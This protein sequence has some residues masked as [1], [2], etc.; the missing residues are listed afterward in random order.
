[1]TNSVTKTDATTWQRLRVT[2]WLMA[3]TSVCIGSPCSAQLYDP[4]DTYPPRWYLG[5]TDCDAKI[6]EQKHLLDGGVAGGSCEVINFAAANGS[7]AQLVYPIEPVLPLDDLIASVKVMSAKPGA[8]IGFRVRFPYVKD[9][10]T[11]KVVAVTL[12]GADYKAPGEFALLGI[13]SIEKSLRLKHVALRGEYGPGVDLADPYVDAVLINAY[14]GAGTTAIRIDELRVDGMVPVG[15]ELTDRSMEQTVPGG[16]KDSSRS[17]LLAE[18]GPVFPA[19]TVTRILQ[20]NG[21][22]LG[23]VR[24]LGFDAILTSEMPDADLL[25]A[26]IQNRLQIYSPPPS[27]IDPVLESLLE[28]VAGWFLGSSDVLDTSTLDQ[29]EKAVQRLR[30]FPE[31][32]QRPMI[33]APTES[34]SSYSAFLDGLIQDLPPRERSLSADEEVKELNRRLSRI[35]SHVGQG[36]AVTSMP[37]ESILRQADSIAEAVGVPPPSSFH[38]HAMWLQTMRSLECVPS[39]VLYRST[40]SLA[41]GQPMDTQR[42]LALSYVNRMIAMISPWV[43]TAVNE[44]PPSIAEG[45]Y[46][47]SRLGNENADLLILTS[48]ASRGSET[49]AGDGGAIQLQLTPGDVNQTVW[50][51]TH[52]TAERLVPE[53]TETGPRLEIVSPDVVELIILSSDP[54]VGGQ[55]A[56]AAGQ[57]A[58]KATTDR[59]QLVSDAV[60]RTESRWIAAESMS[61]IPQQRSSNLVQ[62]AKRTMGD[63]EPI[64]RSGDFGSAL[65]MARR[66]D[67]WLLRSEWQLSERLMPD[68]PKPTS[69]PPVVMGAAELQ[70]FWRPLM[71]DRGWGRNRLTS[72]SMDELEFFSPG[73]WT[74]GKRLMDRAESNVSRETLG[75]FSGPGALRASVVSLT[76]DPLPGGYEGTVVQIKSPSVRLAAGSGVRIDAWVRT[77]GFGGPH[78]GLLMYDSIVGPDLGILVRNQPGWTPVRLYRQT[79]RDG[80]LHVI[81]EV[82]GA[83]EIMVDEVEIR[84]WEPGQKIDLPVK[85]V[86]PP[87]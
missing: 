86:L 50:R 5:R 10:T 64:F 19:E 29:T 26:A 58:R 33:G 80:E 13:G 23:W 44:V 72:G 42:A 16:T 36:V 7:E 54:S 35:G 4:L 12:Y 45:S 39:T 24:S 56:A 77:I 38:W 65:R 63:A 59:W 49:L 27:R 83:G 32:W 9:P 85:P 47:C 6:V 74:V 79:E 69:S 73:R 15:R 37:A 43:V 70:I 60:M 67:A 41:S 57:F 81:F 2:L 14:S 66:A 31:R 87:R 46:R 20:Y 51:L 34:W 78:Q 84:V 17:G 21:E 8:T 3:L 40:R 61:R 53:M 68:W 30:S 18:Q 25:R 11:K 1:M 55:I 28:P 52:F 76:D 62:A 22:P 82:L 48:T 71:D 75:A